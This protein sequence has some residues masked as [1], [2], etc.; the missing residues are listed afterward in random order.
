MTW[1][2]KIVIWVQNCWLGLFDASG[3]DF[4]HLEQPWHSPSIL[5]FYG[6]FLLGLVHVYE[7]AFVITV[8][9]LDCWSFINNC[10]VCL[11]YRSI[12]LWWESYDRSQILWDSCPFW[13]PWHLWRGILSHQSRKLCAVPRWDS[14]WL[15]SSSKFT[16]LGLI[17]MSF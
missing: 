3:K 10:S 15:H 13:N 11:L 8:P 1:C 5:L 4:L 2:F 17:L 14:A 9:W 16:L 12:C 7:A 6:F